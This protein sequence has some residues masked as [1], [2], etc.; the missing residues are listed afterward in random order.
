[1]KARKKSTVCT[2]ALPGGT[3]TTAASSGACKP[4]STSSR[5]SGCTAGKRSR[6]HRGADLGAAAAAA[7]GNRR[8]GLRRFGRASG[9]SPWPRPAWP[10]P[11]AGAG[12]TL[13]RMKRRS[14]QSFQR[15][16]QSPARKQRAARSDG[17]AVAGADQR[18]P[19]RLRTVG[20]QRLRVTRA[21][22]VVGQRRPMAHGK[23]AGLF[24]PADRPSRR[25]RRP[26]R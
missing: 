14:I 4:I 21:A 8:D 12:R 1:M 13:N 19:A 5:S 17:V 6:Q 11:S 24:Q 20:A 23:N 2:I 16:T 18:Q 25:S 15:H 7:H 22:Q 3:R 10:S 9:T 26:R